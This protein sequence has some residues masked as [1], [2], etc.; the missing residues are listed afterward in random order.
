[1][2]ALKIV[3][4]AIFGKLGDENG[5][6]LDL[7]ALY[8]TTI[9]GQLYLLKLIEMLSIKG[10]QNVSANT[11]GIIT[12][13]PIERYD[14]FVSICKE[15]EALFN[16]QLEFTKYHKYVCYAVNDYIAIK[17]SYVD[18]LNEDDIKK[19][20]LFLTDIAVDKGRCRGHRCRRTT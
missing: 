12:E 18:T 1:M 8:A 10:F 5:P 4:N 20:G 11:D 3:V 7:K 6:L 9:N 13:I 17:D 15:W 2:E 14:E 19:K 16:F